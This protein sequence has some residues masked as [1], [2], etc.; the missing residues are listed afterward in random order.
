[1][2]GTV[3][4]VECHYIEGSHSQGCYIELAYPNGTEYDWISVP[5]NEGRR[6][7]LTLLPVHCFNICVYDWEADSTIGHLPIPLNVAVWNESCSGLPP[8]SG[9]GQY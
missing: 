2:N 5:R 7:V 6:K 1:M 9:S 3:A 4:F 8:T